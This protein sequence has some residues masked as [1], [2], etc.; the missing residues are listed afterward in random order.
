MAPHLGPWPLDRLI[1]P[2]R[3]VL[4]GLG[5][6]ELFAE[7]PHTCDCVLCLQALCKEIQYPVSGSK[8]DLR[9][10]IKLW[11]D[12]IDY[13]RKR[14]RRQKRNAAGKLTGQGATHLREDVRL[15][16]RQFLRKVI[17]VVS[18]DV[19]V[20]GPLMLPLDASEFKGGYVPDGDGD[21]VQ[22]M[23]DLGTVASTKEAYASRLWSFLNESYKDFL[24]GQ[25]GEVRSC[26]LDVLDADL[27]APNDF[28]GMSGAP[29]HGP[30]QQLPAALLKLPLSADQLKRW[31]I[32]LNWDGDKRVSPDEQLSR[33]SLYSAING[34]NYFHGIHKREVGAAGKMLFQQV[35]K[36][37]RRQEAQLRLAGK[38]VS[39]AD[40]VI[41]METFQ[42]LELAMMGMTPLNLGHGG[43][44]SWRKMVLGWVYSLLTFARGCRRKSTGCVTLADFRFVGT[45]LDSH[46]LSV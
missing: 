32:Y 29:P 27:E 14:G 6:P 25:W 16:R 37:A 38:Q 20:P 42:H 5:L 40:P 10:R 4:W 35:R 46:G 21:F 2:P 44:S 13:S 8:H 17:R 15:P 19:L 18:A 33:P 12:G 1:V 3:G 43:P 7:A 22:E 9:K 24:R 30:S 41:S 45:W 28:R 34:L 26:R 23:L 11:L 39:F 36:G 31:F